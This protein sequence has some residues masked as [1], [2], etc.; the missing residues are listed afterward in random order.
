LSA[1]PWAG[2]SETPILLTSGPDT[3]GPAVENYLAKYRST[4]ANGVVFGDR[5]S[6]SDLATARATELAQG[7]AVT[8]DLVMSSAD[9]TGTI[10]VLFHETGVVGPWRLGNALLERLQVDGRAVDIAGF[11]GQV[12]AGDQIVYQ[13]AVGGVYPNTYGWNLVNREPTRFPQRLGAVT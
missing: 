4:L 13:P 12:S 3:L 11:L 8:P 6:V 2:I 5:R 7:S 1:S 9:E 10:Q